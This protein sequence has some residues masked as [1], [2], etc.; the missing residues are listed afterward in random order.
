MQA[1][2]FKAVAKDHT[3]RIPDGVPDGIPLRVL[4]LLDEPMIAKAPREETVR[5]SPA[6][7]LANSVVYNDDLI[8]PAADEGEWDALR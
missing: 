4:V 3:L 2:E 7:E 1:I 5:R 6:P 8:D